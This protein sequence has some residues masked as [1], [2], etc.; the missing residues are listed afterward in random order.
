MIR[1]REGHDQ[2][3][4]L[5]W[6]SVLGTLV[7]ELTHND[8]GEHSAEFYKSMDK[9]YDEVEASSS[10]TGSLWGTRTPPVPKYQ[11]DGKSSKLGGG[12]LAKN[13]GLGA[14]DVRQLAAE[15]ALRRMGQ[16]HGMEGV[17]VL[18]GRAAGPVKSRKELFL[19]SEEHR[20]G[21][22]VEGGQGC[23]IIQLAS[24]SVPVRE[25][26]YRSTMSSGTEVL[27]QWKWT[28]QICTEENTSRVPLF[29]P[30]NGSSN[31]SSGSSSDFSR[32][33]SSGIDIDS[34]NS[35][36]A[37]ASGETCAWCGCPHGSSLAAG[38]DDSTLVQP[39]RSGGNSKSSSSSSI[40][41]EYKRNRSGTSGKLAGMEEREIFC[42]DCD[43]PIAAVPT[44]AGELIDLISPTGGSRP[45]TGGRTAEF[46]RWTQLA[47]LTCPCC[48][49]AEPESIHE[50][51]RQ[52]E[53]AV[54]LDKSSR[55]QQHSSDYDAVDE[56]G[57]V[58]ME[59]L[60][61][62]VR[63]KMKSNGSVDIIVL[64]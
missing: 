63:K 62:P 5:P 48:A 19:A 39:E 35:A 2:M 20:R 41:I 31:S 6:E 61:S 52:K 53:E 55:S 21:L 54:E 46:C 24:S 51:G 36:W 12:K 18:G 9:L 7:H 42:I 4:F 57:K 59:A 27:E 30:K 8:I 10:D 29:A 60:A 45:S 16:P 43:P 23:S 58:K 50:A 13:A 56:M 38:G 44:A 3:S 49:P 1:L 40:S 32:V 25:P 26:V 14:G 64:D 37:A 15:A 47:L 34:T 33:I 22:E 28:C 11:F 17:R